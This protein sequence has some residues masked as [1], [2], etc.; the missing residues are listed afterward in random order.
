MVE[1]ESSAGLQDWSKVTTMEFPPSLVSVEENGFHHCHMATSENKVLSKCLL[2]SEKEYVP[3]RRDESDVLC[4]GTLGLPLWPRL[5][6][7]MLNQ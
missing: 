4:P 2:E 1:I 3:M 5:T 6:A 7:D